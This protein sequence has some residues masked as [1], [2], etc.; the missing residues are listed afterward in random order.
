MFS[1]D[2]YVSGSFLSVPNDSGQKLNKKL[3]RK[4]VWLG[5]GGTNV[6]IQHTNS[7]RINLVQF[8]MISNAKKEKRSRYNPAPNYKVSSANLDA[9]PFRIC[10]LL[11]PHSFQL[12]QPFAPTWIMMP[13]LI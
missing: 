5:R 13:S 3:S 11:R 2:Q 10:W 8:T 6:E 7:T 4:N 9:R 12:Q 1:I